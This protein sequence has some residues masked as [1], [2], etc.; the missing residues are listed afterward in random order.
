M[1]H[2]RINLCNEI[3]FLLSYDYLKWMDDMKFFKFVGLLSLGITLC[4]TGGNAATLV[5]KCNGG[6]D[7]VELNT[8]QKTLEVTMGEQGAK[9]RGKYKKTSSKHT[10]V[11]QLGYFEYNIKKEKGYVSW[12]PI[13]ARCR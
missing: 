6:I 7:R 11:G 12:G 4:S 5:Y 3:I 9:A 10:W 2:F 13:T 8:S 1:T